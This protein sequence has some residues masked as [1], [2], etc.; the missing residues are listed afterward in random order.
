LANL[1]LQF[2]IKGQF[3]FLLKY[4]FTIEFFVKK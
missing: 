3:L 4:F 1:F 2:V